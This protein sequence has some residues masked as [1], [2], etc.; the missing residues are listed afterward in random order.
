MSHR[1]AAV[2]W[3]GGKDCAL[4]LCRAQDANFDIACLATFHPESDGREPFKAHP[5]HLVRQIAAEMHLSHE[6]LAVGENYEDGYVRGLHYLRGRYGIDTVITGD[7][8][9]VDGK[10]NWI[11][12]CCARAGLQAF[13]PLWKAPREELLAEVVERGIVARISWI[14]S[15][16]IP[17]QWLGRTIDEGFIRD[18]RALAARAPVDITGE[19]GEYHTMVSSVQ[20]PLPR[21]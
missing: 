11:T 6:L 7:I 4:A 19:N 21:A 9:F 1:R 8:D 15:E 3:T 5:L 20:F 14:N 2:L 10:P 17:P 13:M 18:I 16:H 12:H